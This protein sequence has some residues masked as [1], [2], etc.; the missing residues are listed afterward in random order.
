MLQ[1]IQ[2]YRDWKMARCALQHA[3]DSVRKYEISLTQICDKNT[4]DKNLKNE[5]LFNEVIP[6]PKDFYG[7]YDMVLNV[8]TNIQTLNS[9]AQKYHATSCFYKYDRKTRQC[10]NFSPNDSLSSDLRCESCSQ[11]M[12]LKHLQ[13]LNQDFC[14]KRQDYENAR[15]KL[16]NDFC[17]WKQRTK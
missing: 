15:N 8:H 9:A 11:F 5:Q 6:T 4:W 10:I 17:F 13:K 1:I 3:E 2:D 7:L 12:F 16:L 14:D